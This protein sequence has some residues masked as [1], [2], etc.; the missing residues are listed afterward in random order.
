MVVTNR[1]SSPGVFPVYSLNKKGQ[2]FSLYCK[3]QMLTYKPWQTTQDSAWGEP[4]NDE[5]YVTKW[6]E[7]LKTPYAEKKHS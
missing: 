6:K 7:F 4:G 1:K 2:N 5:I 3:Y